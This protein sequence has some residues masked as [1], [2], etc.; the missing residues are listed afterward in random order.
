[1]A[2]KKVVKPGAV[3]HMVVT[4]KDGDVTFCSDDLKP[5]PDTDVWMGRSPAD[6]ARLEQAEKDETVCPACVHA[7]KWHHLGFEQGLQNATG[8]L[9]QALTKVMG[10]ANVEVHEG[11]TFT[12][13]KLAH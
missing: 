11:N 7:A 1:M 10:K 4:F 5:N 9:L 2:K 12:A 3:V 6:K 13:S 8:G